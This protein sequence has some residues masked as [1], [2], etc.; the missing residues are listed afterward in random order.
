[1]NMLE[2]G[3][4]ILKKVGGPRPP[5]EGLYAYL[6]ALF[7]G[8]AIADLSVMQMRPLFLPTEAPPTP[9]ASRPTRPVRPDA[10]YNSIVSRNVFDAD[11][12]IPPPLSSDETEEVPTEAQLSQLP[13]KLMGTIVHLNP[14]KSVA[15]ILLQSSNETKHY[16]VEDEIQGMARVTKIERRKVTFQNLNNHRLE[17]IEIPKDMELNFG[18]KPK[19]SDQSGAIN[20]R[21]QFDFTVNR[22]EIAKHTSNLQ[23]VLKDARMVRNIVPGTGGRVEGFRFAWIKPGSI[24]EKLGFKSNDVIKEVNGEE[25]NSPTKAMELYNAL[26]TDQKIDIVV[27]RNGRDE[28]FSY[29]ITE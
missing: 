22:S 19:Q 24:Y 17:Y 13:L 14:A 26:K 4:K 16:Q 23:G 15:S 27:E 28:D 11:N 1:M 8:F 6:L 5:L 7:A 18:F 25:V 20:A 29:T 21:G 2:Q 3:T 12:E 9:P 10:S